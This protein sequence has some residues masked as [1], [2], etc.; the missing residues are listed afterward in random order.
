MLANVRDVQKRQNLPLSDKLVVSAGCKFNLDVEMETGT[1]K[2][3]CYIKTIFEMN[4]RYG[5]SKFI[6]M[7]PSI[8]IRE[9]VY[10]SLQITADHFTESYGKKARFFIYNSKQLHELESFSSDAGINVM[11]INIQAFAAKGADN[12]RIYDELDDFQSR[13][14]IDVIASNRPILILDEPQK[15][16]GKATMEAL[17]KFKPLEILRYSATHKTQHN[18]IHRLDALDAYNQKLVKKIAVRGI[19]PAG[20]PER[21]PTST[22]KESRFPKKAPVAR[23]E[24]EVRLKSGEIKRQ[25]QAAGVRAMTYLT[26]LASWTNTGKVHRSRRSTQSKTPSSS[27]MA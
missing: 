11:V 22:L 20:L 13:S 19:K 26:I 7:V 14:P 1:G 5:W 17:P 6:I 10:K 12:R 2:T 16:E 25:T 23:V 3:Y 27:P 4:K 15:M 24:L 9:G 21:M 8:A 18:R